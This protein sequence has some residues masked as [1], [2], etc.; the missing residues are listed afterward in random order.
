[1]SVVSDQ[2]RWCRRQ[3]LMGSNLKIRFQGRRQHFD[4]LSD[5]AE[6]IR[7]FIMSVVSD[8]L[9]WCRR[10]SLMVPN[11]EMGNGELVINNT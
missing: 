1:M 5:R 8:Q 4:K 9:R 10:Q 11:L 3:S 7:I 2:L 6:G